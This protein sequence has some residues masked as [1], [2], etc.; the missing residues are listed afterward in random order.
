MQDSGIFDISKS[1]YYRVFLLEKAE[2]EKNQWYLSEKLGCDVGY[3]YARFNWIMQY[4]NKFINGLKES[5]LY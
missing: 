3:S 1:D 5:G 2:I 4:R